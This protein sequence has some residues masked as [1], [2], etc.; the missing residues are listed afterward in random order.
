LAETQSTSGESGSPPRAWGDFHSPRCLTMPSRFTPTRVGRLMPRTTADRRNTVHPHARG[1]ISTSWQGRTPVFGSPPR[2]WG[3]CRSPDS[4]AR[5]RA[6]HP[7][8]RGEIVLKLI[9]A[10]LVHGSPPRAWGDW[11]METPSSA[12]T[13]F[14]P[15]RVGRLRS[16]WRAPYSSP[17]HPHVRGEIVAIGEPPQHAGGSPPRAWGDYLV[18]V[19][20]LDGVRFTPTRVGRFAPMIGSAG[21]TAVHP[22][23]RGEILEIPCRSAIR[24]GSPPRAWGDCAVSL[25]GVDVPRFTPTRVGRFRWRPALLTRR[26]VHPHARGEILDRDS[27]VAQLF[28]SPPRAWGDCSGTPCQ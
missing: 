8:A 16:F 14:T 23:A 6:V 1:E 4:R 3:D 15:T 11:E 21:S 18:L 20:G 19:R 2:A 26:P 25:E 28:G 12:S 13:R 17:V 9:D 7:H 5:C 24:H 27:A 22:H 10:T